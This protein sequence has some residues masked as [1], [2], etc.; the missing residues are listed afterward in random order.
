MCFCLA[1]ILCVSVRCLCGCSTL[2][3][4]FW[5]TSFVGFSYKSTKMPLL[6]WRFSLLFCSLACLLNRCSHPNYTDFIFRGC[7]NWLTRR[8]LSHILLR[9]WMSPWHNPGQWICYSEWLHRLVHILIPSNTFFLGCL[10]GSI[11][12]SDWYGTLQPEDFW[13]LYCAKCVG[14]RIKAVA[15]NQRLEREIKYTVFNVNTETPLEKH[16]KQRYD[17]NYS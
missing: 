4:L 7:L 2:L 17:F 6:F 5:Q 1:F 8:S 9:W 12:M 13:P 3:W 15:Q 16:R 10:S 14:G 11:S